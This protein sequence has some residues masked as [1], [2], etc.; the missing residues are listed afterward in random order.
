[1]KKL[2]NVLH[3]L[4]E[5]LTGLAGVMLASERMNTQRCIGKDLDTT[6]TIIDQDVEKEELTQEELNKLGK[7]ISTI[8]K[9]IKG[10]SGVM[11]TSERINT[12]RCIGK[13]LDTTKTIIDQ[14]VDKE[15]FTEEEISNLVE[16]AKNMVDTMLVSER[17][18]SQRCIGKD[19]DTTKTIIDPK[20]AK[21]EIDKEEIGKKEIE[22]L[23]HELKG[24]LAE[25]L[26]SERINSQRCIGKDL[27]T[28]KTII[29]NNKK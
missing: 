24:L 21:K 16:E 2:G 7:E 10:I 15:E 22:K 17:I 6:K 28:T 1:M 12:Q 5:E 29:D 19:L 9:E 20:E 11:L 18:N 8:A 4:K 25:M 27:D 3:G 23:V 13:D 26:V 14:S